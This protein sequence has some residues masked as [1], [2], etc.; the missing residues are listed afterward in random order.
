MWKRGKTPS[1]VTMWPPHGG[2]MQAKA[3][4]IVILCYCTIFYLICIKS[5]FVKIFR[6]L[7][8][9]CW[10]QHPIVGEE[11]GVTHQPQMSEPPL[12]RWCDWNEVNREVSMQPVR[13]FPPGVT[14]CLLCNACLHKDAVN[15][16]WEISLISWHFWK[17][18]SE[19]HPEILTQNDKG[20]SHQI[21][22]KLVSVHPSKTCETATE[23]APWQVE[24]ARKN[25]GFP[26]G[27]VGAPAL[28][29]ETSLINTEVPA[30][31]DSLSWDT[32]LFVCDITTLNVLPIAGGACGA[33][34]GGA[35]LSPRGFS[36][37]SFPRDNFPR[38]AHAAGNWT[39]KKSTLRLNRVFAG[40]SQDWGLCCCV[41]SIKDVSVVVWIRWGQLLGER[42]GKFW[43]VRD[44]F[45]SLGCLGVIWDSPSWDFKILKL[46]GGNS[47]NLSQIFG[48][49]SA[50]KGEMI[51]RLPELQMLFSRHRVTHVR[52]IRC[53]VTVKPLTYCWERWTFIASLTTSARKHWFLTGAKIENWSITW[54]ITLAAN[55]DQFCKWLTKIN[56]R[57]I[58][59][60]RK[61]RAS[62]STMSAILRRECQNHRGHV[63]TPWGGGNAG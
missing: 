15:F 36:K 33:M 11:C 25:G 8:F 47:F 46:L 21:V 16:K 54:S 39:S 26:T 53:G 6:I 22:Y 12:T 59:C 17:N 9:V 57:V 7:K 40:N 1:H 2:G 50:V 35:V 29:I 49:A 55:G 20:C 52:S 45:P 60:L 3:S 37:E 61:L 19:F 62:I 13:R 30:P 48:L 56:R 32:N 42:R 10:C 38:T 4:K 43:N 51:A 63:I 27:R 18:W 5:I 41:T 58:S 28:C 24:F 34:A 31:G 14:L 23:I 44:H